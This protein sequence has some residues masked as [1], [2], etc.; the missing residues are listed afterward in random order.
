MSIHINFDD[1]PWVYLLRL[2]DNPKLKPFMLPS[3]AELATK[4]LIKGS[5]ED[6]NLSRYV[7][8]PN[9]KY[10]E[11]SAYLI[12]LLERYEREN[13]FKRFIVCDYE[14]FLPEAYQS[15]K[16]GLNGE[17]WGIKYLDKM[18]KFMRVGRA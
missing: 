3:V 8:V 11:F 4:I 7:V 6:W 15:Y 2:S 18:L 12:G 17:K 10:L 5:Y 16:K 1:E 13:K 14:T 9:R